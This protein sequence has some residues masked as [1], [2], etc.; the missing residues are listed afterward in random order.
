M[1]FF[2]VFPP[3]NFL[4]FL[5]KRGLTIRRFN[6][7]LGSSRGSD[8]WIGK[9]WWREILAQIKVWKRRNTLCISSFQTEELG[10]KI[11]QQPQTSH[12]SFS[13]INP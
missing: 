9:D 8:D 12:S 4:L 2:I 7:V 6:T 3:K 1:I 13:Q 10:Q 11:R 5:S